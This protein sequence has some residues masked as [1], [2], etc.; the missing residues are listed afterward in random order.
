VF[1][2]V[3]VELWPSSWE[4]SREELPESFRR[5]I[6]G[7]TKKGKVGLPFQLRMLNDHGLRCTCFVESLFAR[8]F[9]VEPL[10]DIVCLIDGGGQDIQLHAHPEWITHSARP[11]L[12]TRGRYLLSQFNADE[13]LLLIET[14]LEQL[15]AA[16]APAVTAFRAGSFAANADTLED[17]TRAGLTVDSSLK[18]G[19]E[20]AR[21]PIAEYRS[22]GP[23]RRLLEYPLSTYE[24]WPGRMRHLQLTAC[25]FDEIVFVLESAR[26]DDWEAVVLLSHSA[27]LIDRAR[28]LPDRIVV[29]R[30]EKLCGWLADR[31]QEYVT[32][33]LGMDDGGT[34]R[35][36]V[37]STL[38]S[39]R[40]RTLGRIAEQALRKFHV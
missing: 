24:D 11:V 25:S 21:S 34:G 5:F 39:T 4:K 3:D 19:S 26:R 14:A 36:V 12:E 13:Q 29:R 23:A 30:F 20:L 1:L 17:V 28:F 40:W 27:E 32:S 22:S 8:D 10:R 33:G 16:G 31:R 6:L 15:R 37:A 35:G 7:E 9:G 2:T 38:R 18:L